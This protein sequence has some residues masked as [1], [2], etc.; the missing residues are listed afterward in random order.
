LSTI[1]QQKSTALLIGYSCF[2]NSILTSA[3]LSQDYFF[4]KQWQKLNHKK[5]SLALRM[6]KVQNRLSQ[7]SATAI[8]GNDISSSVL[9]VSALSTT[10]VFT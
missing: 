1:C 2:Y 9:Y 4:E 3:K 7:L 8:C 10:V 5:A 6:D